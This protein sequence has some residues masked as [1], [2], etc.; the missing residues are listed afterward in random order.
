MSFGSDAGGIEK[1][2]IEFL[3]FLIQENH[4]VDLYLWRKPGILFSKIPSQVNH[5][6]E[7]LY[8]GSLNFKK[9]I[10]RFIWYIKFRINSILKHPVK[11]FKEFPIKDYDIAISYCQNGFSPHYIIDKVQAK[12]KIMFYHHGSYEISGKSKIIDEQHYLKYDSFIT[13]SNTNKIML[14]KQFP[15]MKGRISV[16][17]NLCDE[18]NILKLSQI[19]CD[20]NRTEGNYIFCTVGRLSPE[21]GQTLAIEVA[22]ELKHLG[23][24]FKWY[25]VGDGPDKEKCI[26]LVAKYELTSNCIFTGMLPN[27]YPYING[28]DIYIQTSFVEADPVTIREA[29]ILNKIII[30]SDIPALKEALYNYKRGIAVT[31]DPQVLANEI[32]NEIKSRKLDSYVNKNTSPND[33]IINQLR[34]VLQ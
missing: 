24:S 14:E 4:T 25:F 11:C 12:K 1:S 6:T 29:K 17:N 7:E 22:R 19:P 32:S 15:S 5:I 10:K 8:P 9:G 18:M 2:L 23:L 28:C 26:Q 13:V 16:I 31:S 20:I 34:K 30:T 27:P 33:L 3:K 21:K